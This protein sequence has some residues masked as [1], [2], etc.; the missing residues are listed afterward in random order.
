M[1]SKLSG[2]A[3]TKFKWK[4]IGG[5][6]HRMCLAETKITKRKISEKIEINHYIY[7]YVL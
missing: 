6:D 5:L 3:K 1:L 2:L 7:P 4:K